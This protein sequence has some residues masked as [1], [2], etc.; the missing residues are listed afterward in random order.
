MIKFVAHLLIDGY[1]LLHYLDQNSSLLNKVLKKPSKQSL[2]NQR[3][4]NLQEKRELLLDLLLR[5]RI[6]KEI[7]IS[8][9]FDSSEK[10]FDLS[11]KTM[12]GKILVLFSD[13]GETADLRIARLCQQ[14]PSKY[15]VVSN[16]QEVLS[17]ARLYRCLTMSCR[18]FAPKLKESSSEEPWFHQIDE[19]SP[20][21]E[22]DGPLYPRVST[23]KKGSSKKLPKRE[24]QRKQKLKNL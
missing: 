8:L 11:P 19:L 4:T 18:E 22:E 15:V 16:D 24:R 5:Y 10:F 7:E 20:E 2:S 9:V 17:A 1:N 21:S 13:P 14:S 3:E 12:F 23:K 6:Q